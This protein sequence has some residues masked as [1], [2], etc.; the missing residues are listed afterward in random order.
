MG[1]KLKSSR[2]FNYVV[3]A[4]V[5]LAFA[6]ANVISFFLRSDGLGSADGIRRFGFP[7]II[8]EV[9]GFACRYFFSWPALCADMFI[10]VTYAAV[11]GFIS[12]R[13]EN[14]KRQ[15]DEVGKIG[16]DEMK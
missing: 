11:A 10:S 1:L 3:F 4:S 6:V 2:K 9:G 15:A 13:V 16:R 12:Q 8:W 7:W 14:R 5:L